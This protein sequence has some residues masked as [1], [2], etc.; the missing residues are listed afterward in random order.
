MRTFDAVLCDIDGC[1]QPESSEPADAEGLA[2][3]ARH[4]RRALDAAD[5]PVVTL[6]SGRPAPFVEALCRVLHNATIP[7][8]AENGVWV[9]DPRDGSYHQDPAITPA[10]RAA[11]RDA[12]AWIED[13]LLPQ[14]VVIQPGKSA[15]ISLFHPDTPRLRAFADDITR[16]FADRGW[17]FRVSM[18]VAWINCDLAHISKGT[19]IDRVLDA[20]G[21]AKPRLAGVGDSYSDLPIAQRVAFFACPSNADH[22]LKAHAH[23]VSPHAE[24]EGVLDILAR[25]HPR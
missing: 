19:G 1:L 18:T 9:Y 11:V 20:T 5:R 3:V 4:N 14:G 17:P 10:H 16:V 13:H 12:T 25:L 2:A 21:L 6:C 15:S 7:C 23:Y 22:R 8:V 24:L